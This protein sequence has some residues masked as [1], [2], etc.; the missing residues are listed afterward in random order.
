MK[1]MSEGHMFFLKQIYRNSRNCRCCPSRKASAAAV[2]FV[3]S[4]LFNRGDTAYRS[5]SLNPL[6][7]ISAFRARKSD[8]KVFTPSDVYT[9]KKHRQDFEPLRCRGK[10]SRSPTTHPDSTNSWLYLVSDPVTGFQHG[11]IVEH[12]P[13]YPVRFA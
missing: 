6:R 10:S 4:T 3:H 5:A 8:Q 9:L 12:A 2:V 13:R 11:R 7:L 1:M